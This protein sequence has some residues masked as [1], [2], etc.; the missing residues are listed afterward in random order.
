[1]RFSAYFVLLAVMAVGNV[2]VPSRWPA[3]LV[4]AILRIDNAPLLIT[5]IYGPQGLVWCRETFSLV[6]PPTTPAPPSTPVPTPT[7]PTGVARTARGP[8][9]ARVRH[10][11]LAPPPRLHLHL[12]GPGSARA[13]L[14]GTLRA[15]PLRSRRDAAVAA[16]AVFVAV[17]AAAWWLRAAWGGGGVRA[18]WPTLFAAPRALPAATLAATPAATP[19]AAP[20]APPA[21][22]PA[23]AVAIADLPAV[24]ATAP[25]AAPAVS[26]VPAAPHVPVAPAAV[27]RERSGE[28][29]PV[30]VPGVAAAP[31]AP[32][33]LAAPGAFGRP[34]TDVWRRILRPSTD[35]SW[36]YTDEQLDAVIRR[37]V[38]QANPARAACI[39]LVGPTTAKVI[40]AGT[41]TRENLDDVF[42]ATGGAEKVLVV[43]HD[44]THKIPHWYLLV[45]DT[46][47]HAVTVVDSL[48]RPRLRPP[49]EVWAGYFRQWHTEN[50]APTVRHPRPHTPQTG[51]ECGLRT[52]MAVADQYGVAGFPTTR[53]GLYEW[54]P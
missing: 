29:P 3:P 9:A 54:R 12:A 22:L 44:G 38:A 16:T 51:V 23:P 6:V 50:R 39:H 4:E 35:D 48:A 37:I 27:R 7:P 31:A 41:A 5:T 8:N 52:L 42:I 13:V 2:V 49:T 47:A 40:A 11:A 53:R 25:L 34:V 45:Y 1:M 30:P 43:C 14:A 32:A 26:A 33:A 28:N 24:A 18:A 15:L 17:A 46:A 20:A 19:A 36:L 10:A 21:A